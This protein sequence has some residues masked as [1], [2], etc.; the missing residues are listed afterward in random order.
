MRFYFYHNKSNFANNIVRGSI[1]M[2][3]YVKVL[4]FLAE[5]W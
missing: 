1:Q 5:I 2:L 3:I 4:N